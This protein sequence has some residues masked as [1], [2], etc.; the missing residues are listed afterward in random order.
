MASAFL[1]VAVN[2]HLKAY[3]IMNEYAK[4]KKFAVAEN[5]ENCFVDAG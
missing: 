5:L 2:R 3:D 1:G 4:V